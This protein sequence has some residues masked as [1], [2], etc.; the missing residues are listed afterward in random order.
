MCL[1]SKSEKVFVIPSFFL[2]ILTLLTPISFSP[3]LESVCIGGRWGLWGSKERV[4]SPGHV[5]GGPHWPPH[6]PH[7]QHHPGRWSYNVDLLYFHVVGCG[8]TFKPH[9]YFTPS[10]NDDTP[11]SL[12]YNDTHSSYIFWSRFSNALCCFSFNS[13]SVS[14]HSSVSNT[15]FFPHLLQYMLQRTQDPDENVALE[16]CEFWLTLA[17]QPICKEMLS[18]HLVQWVACF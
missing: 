3:L 11:S 17:E 15:F 13:H 7:A 4:P 6:P 10:G 12:I 14:A 16:A 5:T 2:K 8:R 18:G 1:S 9:L